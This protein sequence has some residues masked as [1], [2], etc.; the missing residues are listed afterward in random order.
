MKAGIHLY[1]SAKAGFLRLSAARE[2]ATAIEY[3]LIASLVSTAIVTALYGLQG[4]LTALFNS[5]ASKF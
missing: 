2:G 3:A 1:R 4:T 5:I